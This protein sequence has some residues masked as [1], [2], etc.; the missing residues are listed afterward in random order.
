MLQGT[1]RWFNNKSGWDF[2]GKEDGED[3][4][5]RY[6]AIKGD[7]GSAAARV[8]PVLTASLIVTKRLS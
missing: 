1:A 5:V 3:I 8:E 4:F 7:K 6:A 2:I